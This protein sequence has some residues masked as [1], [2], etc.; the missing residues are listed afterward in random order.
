MFLALWTRCILSAIWA[1]GCQTW[2]RS[3]R[4]CSS[5]DNASIRGRGCVR[6]ALQLPQCRPLS[7]RFLQHQ[8]ASNSC[9][10]CCWRFQRYE[11]LPIM[12]VDRESS[13]RIV[14]AFCFIIPLCAS[15]SR[16]L[17]VHPDLSGSQ[18]RTLSNPR[19]V[20]TSVPKKFIMR[21]HVLSF[22]S[23][24][25]KYDTICRHDR[26]VWVNVMWLAAHQNGRIV[27]YY[28]LLK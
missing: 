23:E 18:H 9:A 16:R 17:C 19:R 12:D 27:I 14:F 22:T 1:R 24:V 2:G 4:S 15:E 26:Y 6:W 10:M 28:R 8:G 5:D 13:T 3:E 21:L 25:C 20:R 11:F 7:T